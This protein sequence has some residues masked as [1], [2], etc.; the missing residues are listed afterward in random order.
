MT[1]AEKDEALADAREV[2]E[3]IEGRGM[4]CFNCEISESD[5]EADEYTGLCKVH[6]YTRAWIL[7]YPRI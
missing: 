1:E 4:I 2:I 7:K 3:A 5:A 6:Q